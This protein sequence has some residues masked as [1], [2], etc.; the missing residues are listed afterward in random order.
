M[1]EIIS[2]DFINGQMIATTLNNERFIINPDDIE[3]EV[4]GE[5]Q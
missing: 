1:N 4:K 2:I 5:N 3:F